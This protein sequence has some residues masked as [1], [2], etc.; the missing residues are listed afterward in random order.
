M[1][2][3]SQIDIF[4]VFILSTFYQESLAEFSKYY[5][6]AALLRIRRQGF[7]TRNLKIPGLPP[8]YAL[9]VGVAAD[10]APVPTIE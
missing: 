8:K 7:V 2:F 3:K 4:L 5:D 1:I 10:A 6:L 9:L